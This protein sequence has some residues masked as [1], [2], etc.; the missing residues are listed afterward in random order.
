MT[1]LARTSP[2]ESNVAA[3][4]VENFNRLRP[5][6]PVVLVSQDG[7]IQRLPANPP[8]TPWTGA[9][10]TEW[11]LSPG[12]V[13]SSSRIL[14]V[15]SL[16][17]GLFDRSVAEAMIN[18]VPVLVSNHGALPET[19]GD[20]GVVVDVPLCY[21]AELPLVPRADDI[22]PWVEAIVRLWEDSSFYSQVADRCT[23]HS[24][25]WHPSRT[26]PIYEGFSDICTPSRD[27]R[28]Y[29]NG[30]TIGCA[31]SNYQEGSGTYRTEE[32]GQRKRQR[33]RGHTE[34]SGKRGHT[35]FSCN[36]APFAVA[37]PKNSGGIRWTIRVTPA[38]EQAET[39]TQLNGIKP[40]KP[41]RAWDLR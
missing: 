23:T 32:K 14:V 27:R 39:G 30:R 11:A 40:A 5:D 34:Q 41:R 3:K 20:A 7:Q 35:S 36:Y 8:R 10:G 29:R 25:R 16:G 31:A 38:R 13:C 9:D 24:R 22:S 28:Y 2:G 26:I 21:Q 19:V 17:H 6:I 37:I 1:V 15:P 18:G 33:K 12:R 4:L